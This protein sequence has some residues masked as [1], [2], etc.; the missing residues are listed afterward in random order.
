MAQNP[1]VLC[2]GLVNNYSA[3][4]LSRQLYPTG[5]HVQSDL[6]RPLA[7]RTKGAPLAS[8]PLGPVW[9]SSGYERE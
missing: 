3:E 1:P 4:M 2:W 9:S 7:E 6:P 8:P 5:V